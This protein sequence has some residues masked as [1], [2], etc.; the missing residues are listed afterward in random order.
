MQMHIAV[1]MSLYCSTLL[2]RLQYLVIWIAYLKQINLLTLHCL[3]QCIRVYIAVF[4]YTDCIFET[5]YLHIFRLQYFVIWHCSTLLNT[6]VRCCATGHSIFVYIYP[7]SIYISWL[8]ISVYENAILKWSNDWN[9][10]LRNS[11]GE[12]KQGSEGPALSDVTNTVYQCNALSWILRQNTLRR[13][14]RRDW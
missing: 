3:L 7:C 10:L 6:C 4:C 14:K 8:H 12:S 9:T 2:Y 11:D 13:Q 5:N 1:D